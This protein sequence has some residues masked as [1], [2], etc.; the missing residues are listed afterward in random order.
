MEVESSFESLMFVEQLFEK[1]FSFIEHLFSVSQNVFKVKK[2]FRR[3]RC[4][5][6]EIE[7]KI[8]PVSNRFKST[9]KY[10]STAIN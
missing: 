10:I 3:C 8:R 9:H 4:S 6:G 1:A 5:S 2:K 7:V